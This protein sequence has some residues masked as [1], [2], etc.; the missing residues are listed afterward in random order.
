VDNEYFSDGLTE[1]LL[2]M[3]AQVPE[4]KVAARTSSFAFKGK[5]QDVRL[6]ADALGVAH[7]L[8]GS[9]QRA[10]GRVR[11]TAQLIRAEDG[12]HVWS[13]NYDRTLED[14]FGIQDE[15][16]ERVSGA[17]TQSLLGT[18]GAKQITGVG[19][20]DV[21]AY[22]LYLQAIAEQN[23][24]S[25][26]SLPVSEGLLKDALA[27]DPDYLDAK[28]QLVSNYLNQ[29]QTGLRQPDSAIEEM[30]ALLEQVLASRPDDVR[31]RSWML[32]SQ[33]IRGNLT[34]EYLDIGESV[35][36]LR[37]LVAEAPSEVEPKQLLVTALS[38]LGEHDE[39]LALMQDMLLLDP[40]SPTV[41]RD[42]G[43]AYRR[44]DDLDNA[45]AALERSLELEPD[46]P[47]LHSNLGGLSREAGD[48]VGRVRHQMDA[49]EIDPQDH[50]QPG[51][52]AVFLYRL[53]LLDE[54]D[55]FRARSISI[56]PT[57]PM[58]R[59][60]ELFRAV[61]FESEERQLELARQ[62]IEDDVETREGAWG[63]AT[64]TLFEVAERQG[65]SEEALAF[66]EAQIPGFMNY[67]QPATLKVV[68][69][70]LN[71]IIAFYH[72]E[73]HEELHQRLD[74][75]EDV[76]KELAPGGVGPLLRME[77]LA[78]RG[79]T[80]A[81]IAV[82]LDEILSQPAIAFDDIDRNFALGFMVDVAADPRI[83]EALERWRAEKAQAAKDV[84]EYLAGLDDI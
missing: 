41:H 72:T 27:K 38:Q 64:F 57:S 5:E 9:V 39:A 14:I 24:G 42:I 73:S 44:M 67:D 76:F 21:D 15:I 68:V 78:L 50:E 34:G 12:F 58:A 47:V 83:Q 48:A 25:Y 43:F 69:A 46:Q 66:V 6:I 63:G 29:M 84:R 45:R 32:V 62:M 35:N 1:T 81:A 33:V 26:G 11:V 40:L 4:L 79:E 71:A 23:K 30:I 37:A 65:A 36:A 3:L 53:G 56:A 61:Y 28:T 55:R 51:E 2:H 75:L 74:L 59:A 60:S 49:Q 18:G 10:G 7:I 16:A 31:A 8:E 82:A 77:L 17:L 54:G 70:R 80:E 19:T 13:E 20:D 52:I 22:D